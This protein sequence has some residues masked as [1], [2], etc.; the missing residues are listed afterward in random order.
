MILPDINLLVYAVDATSP[1]HPQ[2]RRWWD[3]TLSSAQPVGLCYT[4][5]LGFVRL[6]TNRR[7]FESPLGVAEALDTAESWLEQP[8]ASLL[9]PTGRHWPIVSGLLR[10]APGGANLTTDAHLA[11][12]AIEHGYTLYSNDLDFGRFEELRWKNPLT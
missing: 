10:S 1:F 8:N 11:A 9:A 6:T 2:A 5:L 12:Y 4:S 7:V 3:E